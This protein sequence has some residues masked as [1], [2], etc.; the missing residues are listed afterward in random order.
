M[1]TLLLE[2]SEEAQHKGT[3]AHVSPSKS[4]PWERYRRPSLREDAE[5]SH[6]SGAERNVVSTSKRE[7]PMLRLRASEYCPSHSAT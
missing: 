2:S 5:D 7:T 4:A 1:R 3:H 6:E